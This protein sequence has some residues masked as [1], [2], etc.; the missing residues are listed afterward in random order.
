[1]APGSATVRRAERLNPH[2][3]DH[4]IHH[5]FLVRGR[6]R[7][8]PVAAPPARHSF[9]IGVPVLITTMVPVS[10]LTFE[11]RGPDVFATAKTCLLFGFRSKRKRSAPSPISAGITRM[12]RSTAIAARDGVT[13]LFG[14]RRRGR[15]RFT[16]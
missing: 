4:A 14:K 9:C 10:R 8:Q 1:M 5:S 2:R 12:G 16:P 11:R 15:S 7:C 13:I 6:A 3:I